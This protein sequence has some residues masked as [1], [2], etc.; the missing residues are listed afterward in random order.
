[1]C[2]RSPAAALLHGAGMSLVPTCC[3][4]AA[5]VPS[6]GASPQSRAGGP[7]L[8]TAR[9]AP[10]CTGGHAALTPQHRAGWWMSSGSCLCPIRARRGERCL[11]NV[12][13]TL[14][15]LPGDA[16][17]PLRC[18]CF[19]SPRKFFPPPF[20]SYMRGSTKLYRAPRAALQP[21]QS[22]SCPAL[23]AH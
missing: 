7:R 8:C 19:H 16:P 3:G 9:H 6:S 2:P 22:R 5:S 13:V 10:G 20:H 17:L 21:P 18:K 12:S 11:P 1:M 15:L 4:C 23:G 14:A